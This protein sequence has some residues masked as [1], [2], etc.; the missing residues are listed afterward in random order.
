MA[1]K[2]DEPFYLSKNRGYLTAVPADDFLHPQANKEVAHDSL[3]ETQYFGFSIPEERIHGLTYCWH[4][5]N[6][7]VVSGGVW[8]WRGIKPDAL[9]SEMFDYRTYMSD[10]PLA[11]DLKTYRLDNG[12]GVD[13][14]E[15]L[16]RHHVTYEDVKRGN[17]IDLEYR[18]LAP[19]AL[20]QNGRHFDQAMKVQGEISLLGT[21]YKVNGYNIRDR[22]WGKPRAE[23]HLG[24]PPVVWMTGVFSDEF[25]FCCTAIDDPSLGPDWATIYP[26][27]PTGNSTIGGWIHKDGEMTDVEYVRK[28]T[29][30]NAQTL[31]PEKVQLSILDVK[32]RTFELEADIP[33][34]SI[35]SPWQNC[36]IP[37]CQA[38]WVFKGQIGYGDFQELQ[39]HD[40]RRGMRA[41]KI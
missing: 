41:K 20:W 19:P 35:F 11:N 26:N 9:D 2:I 16:K 15:P 39:L 7:G 40:F 4:H 25:F 3:S 30:R 5:P 32:G 33:A 17:A 28:K 23:D 14:I 6:L 31:I 21:R 10:K 18:A 29:F 37:I 13:I 12:Y 8:V 24:T 22:S 27:F 34:A 36:E 1:A 38:K